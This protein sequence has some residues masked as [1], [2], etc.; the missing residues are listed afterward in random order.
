[1]PKGKIN[2]NRQR[3]KSEGCR[4]IRRNISR[5]RFLQSRRTTIFLKISKIRKSHIVVKT[6]VPWDLQHLARYGLHSL[7]RR[8]DDRGVSPPLG[9]AGI[10]TGRPIFPEF[11]LRNIHQS[12][13]FRPKRNGEK[14]KRRQTNGRNVTKIGVFGPT[15][16]DT[17]YF[18]GAHQKKQT[19]SKRYN[20]E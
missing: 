17:F 14:A 16:G 8:N 4:V 10:G 19:A 15:R 18:K 7:L 3:W 5:P 2:H 6:P 20:Q 11:S 13:T 12:L 1:M 9:N